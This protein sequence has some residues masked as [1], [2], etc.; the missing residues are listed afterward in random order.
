M[1]RGVVVQEACKERERCG[2]RGVVVQEACKERD[3]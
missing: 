3:V 2:I 1:I